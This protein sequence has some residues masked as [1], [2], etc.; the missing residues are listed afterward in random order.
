MF[1]LVPL[2]LKLSFPSSNTSSL[3]DTVYLIQ[4]FASEQLRL[5]LSYRRWCMCRGA[6]QLRTS[7]LSGRGRVRGCCGVTLC[8]RGAAS[9]VLAVIV[10]RERERK[11]TFDQCL[12]KEIREQD[13]SLRLFFTLCIAFFSHCIS[14][15]I[16]SNRVNC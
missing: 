8:G 16:V 12:E 11:N 5:L 3:W 13:V 10:R 1:I 2:N 14:A 15:A 4:T 6:E 7:V 9:A